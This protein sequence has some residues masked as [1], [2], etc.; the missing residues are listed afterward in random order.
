M[1]RDAKVRVIAASPS[2]SLTMM[3]YL[4]EAAGRGVYVK[5]I[6]RPTIVRVRFFQLLLILRLL[7]SLR[8]IR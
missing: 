4:I 1:V 7:S 3:G 6:T 5:V 2:L 8:G